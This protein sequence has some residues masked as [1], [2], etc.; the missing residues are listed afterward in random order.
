MG[1]NKPGIDKI[2][3]VADYFDVG[4][5]YEFSTKNTQLMQFQRFDFC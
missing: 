3:K 5:S 2:Q 4:E 1:K